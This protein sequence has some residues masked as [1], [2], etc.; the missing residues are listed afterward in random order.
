MLATTFMCNVFIFKWESMR[1]EGKSVRAEAEA[2]CP[3]TD[4]IVLHVTQG[5][6]KIYALFICLA[7]S[8]DFFR[9]SARMA[10]AGLELPMEPGLAFNSWYFCF[11]PLK[12]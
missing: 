4:S 5:K 2:G 3:A 7:V 6:N 10:Q 8:F 11:C 1:E 9:Q 12:D